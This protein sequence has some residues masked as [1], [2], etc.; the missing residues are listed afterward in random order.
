[1]A[2][3]VIGCVDCVIRG[4]CLLCVRW[5]RASAPGLVRL[6]E[7][8]GY[9]HGS[10]QPPYRHNRRPCRD[11]GHF[12][13]VSREAFDPVL[14]QPWSR[15]SEKLDHA[16]LRSNLKNSRLFSIQAI[17][18]IRWGIAM[19]PARR[20]EAIPARLGAA[21][22]YLTRAMAARFQ[23]SATLDSEREE[24]LLC[25]TQRSHGYRFYT[26]VTAFLPAGFHT[27][28][29]GC[30]QRRPLE[31]GSIGRI[32]RIKGG[33]NLSIRADSQNIISRSFW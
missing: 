23:L 6:C 33:M 10:I 14:P 25:K 22:K 9:G 7:V 17:T 24:K 26:V 32:F 19:E 29:Y 28:G 1:M 15:K 13:C 20:P 16:Q 8:R 31:N 5:L 11:I 12:G 4:F 21:T 18:S 3:S 27:M 2:R 30:Q